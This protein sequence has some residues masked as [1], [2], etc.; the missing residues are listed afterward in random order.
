LTHL[1]LYGTAACH[2]CEEAAAMLRDISRHTCLSWVEIDIAEDD[3]LLQRY[4]L[5]IPVLHREDTAAE[6]NWPFCSED[7]LAFM[8]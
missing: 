1:Y 6:I 7:I 3:K 5:T 8:R 2:L 4:G